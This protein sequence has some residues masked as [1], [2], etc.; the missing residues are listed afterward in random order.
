MRVSVITP[1]Y[2]RA[3]LLAETIES[4]LNQ[5]YPH[6]E[7]LVLDDGSN[8]DTAA[9]LA[10]YGARIRT[11]FHPNMGETRTVNK[12]FEM[13][14]GDIV[15]VVSSDDPLLPGAVSEVVA[16]FRDRPDAV[17]VYPDWVSIDENGKVIHEERLADYGIGNML[18]ELNWG[19]GP[20][21]FFRRDA[22]R[23]IG[24]RNPRYTYCG[25]MEFWLRIAQHGPLV[26]VPKF[27]ATHRVH[28]GSASV[29]ARGAKMAHEW[30]QVFR[31]TLQL[32]TLPVEVTAERFRILRDACA[33]ASRQY[34][35]PDLRR[36][37][38]FRA[39]AYGFGILHA[40]SRRGIYY[41]LTRPR[42]AV[43]APMW[44]WLCSK[45]YVQRFVR[46]AVGRI[47]RTLF[48]SGVAVL[49]LAL[50]IPS[51]KNHTNQHYTERFAFCTRFLP[52]MWSGQA[53]VIGR[54]LTGLPPEY[55]CFATQPVYGNRHENDFI[56][57]LPGKY[58]DLPPERRLPI[59]RVSDLVRYLNLLWGI[60]QRGTAMA[61]ALKDDPVDTLIACTGDQIDPPA[62]FLAARILRCR[63]FMYFFDD[64]TE[65][66]WADP[67]IQKAIRRIERILALRADGL[68]S[69][70]EY[71][72]QELL[73]RYRKPSSVIRNPTPWMPPRAETA[74]FP[75]DEGEIKLVF[76]GAIYHLN[77]DIFRSIISAIGLLEHANVRL[78]L[79]TAQPAED[80][81]RQGLVGPQVVI[82]SHLPPAE[83]LAVQSSADI[84]LIPF[85]FQ[86]A[87]EGIVRTSGTA[88]L[89][90]YLM[91]GRSVVAICHEN[92][93]LGWYLRKFDCGVA[94]SSEDPAV[95]AAALQT[96]IDDP[97]L[98]ERLRRNAV[99]RAG[100]DFDPS[101]A[102]EALLHDLGFKTTVFRPGQVMDGGAHGKVASVRPALAP[103]HLKIAQV[104]GYDVLGAQVNG[105]LLHRF[106][107][108]RGHDS[109][110][111]VSRKLSNDDTVHQLGSPMLK[112]LNRF[113]ATVQNAVSTHCVLPVLSAG[114]TELPWI[115]NADVVN[116]QLIHNAQFFSLLQLP[117]LSRRRRVILSV[118]DMF[119]FTGHCIYSLDCERW[120]TGCGSCPDLGIP[121]RMLSDTTAANWRLKRWAFGRSHL[122]L[123]VG[124]P[125]QAERVRNSPILGRFPLHYIPYGVDTRVYRVRDKAAI[126][127]KLGLPPD[128][129][130]IAFRSV[131]FHKNFKGTEYIEAALHERTLHNETWLLTFEGKGGLDALR[132]KYKFMELGWIEDTDAIAEALN[133][134][135]LF[136][137][138]S[139]A[140]AFGLMAIESMACGTPVIVFEGTA[141]PETIDAPHSGIAVPYKDSAALARA[142]DQVLGDP[143]LYQRLRENGLRHVAAK[144]SFEAYAEGYLR[145]YE[146][147]TEET[148][149]ARTSARRAAHA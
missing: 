92:S 91:T 108:E 27:L 55:Y 74:P 70:N 51:R 37:A 133:A 73:R 64:F 143:D 124:S 18:L 118:H 112:R 138:P 6:I 33:Y 146:R 140:E 79:Y 48:A 7:Y 32:T 56:G 83:A 17:A 59:G 9:V 45:R 5:D 35:G 107:I 101:L 145:L 130:V 71:M 104:S 69:P 14:T 20:G 57:A 115:A 88:K 142:I 78:H 139:I 125:W 62:A 121:F 1:T 19:I 84:L 96:I 23:S 44:Q 41:A 61:R 10:R 4:V 106:L 76:T 60:L 3:D 36:A 98:R 75:H 87:A 147:L 103:G 54:L 114:I 136:L 123:V 22:L 116:L 13:V 67:A 12:G 15:C 43:L 28:E 128:A 89:A 131:P 40:L 58:Y 102:Q 97:S 31:S 95:I 113:A 132:G 111:V 120:Q 141:L 135:D 8:D 94:I 144:H 110:M 117:R 49:R 52:P 93:F 137:M 68:I 50:R 46:P 122:D 38:G 129:H 90:D 77:Y 63:Y 26:H 66:W 16:A 81:V 2:N 80:L 30:Y 65:Q 39:K 25:D 127:A 34:S 42:R 148:R 21:A 100:V 119:L 105:Y 29:S 11:E 85:S 47:V 53:V 126:R 134:A 24:P 99:E 149:A 109:H 82:H 72:Q 86:P